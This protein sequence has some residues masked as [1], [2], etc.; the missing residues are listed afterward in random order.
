MGGDFNSPRRRFFSGRGDFSVAE[1]ILK[2]VQE[3]GRFNDDGYET[4]TVEKVVDKLLT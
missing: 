1:E 4:T 2:I 3:I